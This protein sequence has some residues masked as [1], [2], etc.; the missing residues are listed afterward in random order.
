MFLTKRRIFLEILSNFFVLSALLQ[1]HRRC[2]D[3][4]DAPPGGGRFPGGEGGGLGCEGGERSCPDLS[5]DY[6]DAQ[7]A[8]APSS[9]SRLSLCPSHALISSDPTRH[10]DELQR[11]VQEYDEIITFIQC[12][13]CS[14]VH[15]PCI[16]LS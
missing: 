9:T 10:G 15:F 3:E 11:R 8:L 5:S 1:L 6:S 2:T 14:I 7:D 4:L 16:A 13:Y 12:L